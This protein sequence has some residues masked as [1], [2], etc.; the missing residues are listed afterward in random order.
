MKQ[1]KLVKAMYQACLVND[2][3]TMAALT[4]LEF[5]KIVKRKLNKKTFSGKW[6]I[7]R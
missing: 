4:E 1:K 7:V 2:V 6:V 3:D 5:K